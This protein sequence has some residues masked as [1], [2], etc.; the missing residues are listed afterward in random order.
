MWLPEAHPYSTDESGYSAKHLK[1]ATQGFKECFTQLL[2]K[3]SLTSLL[4][5]WI[6]KPFGKFNLVMKRCVYRTVATEMCDCFQMLLPCIC[7]PSDSSVDDDDEHDCSH[8]LLCVVWT[9]RSILMQFI[10]A[11]VH[12]EWCKRTF[13][14]RTLTPTLSSGGNPL[15]SQSISAMFSSSS[16]RGSSTG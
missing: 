2:F 6:W 9:C 13:Y 1:A 7:W 15:L 3:W 10:Y 8:S 14:S 5:T 12:V 4:C 16:S 11:H